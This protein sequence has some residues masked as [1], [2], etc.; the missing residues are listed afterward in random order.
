MAEF[1]GLMSPIELQSI[2]VQK[3]SYA[4]RHSEEKQTLYEKGE[5]FTRAAIDQAGKESRQEREV[6]Q[7]TFVLLESS[8]FETSACL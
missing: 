4:R 3:S 8:K 6:L 1:L 7:T 5:S 2:I